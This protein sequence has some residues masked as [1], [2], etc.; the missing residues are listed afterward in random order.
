MSKK[1]SSAHSV[2]TSGNAR[3]PVRQESHNADDEREDDDAV[4]VPAV[5]S[6]LV[7]RKSVSS[8]KPTLPVNKDSGGEVS[9]STAAK[10]AEDASSSPPEKPAK[11]DNPDQSTKKPESKPPAHAIRSITVKKSTAPNPD[12]EEA[13]KPPAVINVDRGSQTDD[14][15][16][17]SKQVY[18]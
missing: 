11:L 16:P 5:G 7:S 13:A 8:K 10:E 2:D 18:R 17:K 1:D 15:V 9:A 14:R 6:V 12:E 4:H 3:T